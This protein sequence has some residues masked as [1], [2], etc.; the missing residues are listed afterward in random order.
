VQRLSFKESLPKG[1]RPDGRIPVN[2]QY[3]VDAKNLSCTPFGAKVMRSFQQPITD[4]ALT[5]ASITKS[6]PF[7]QLFVGKSATLLA[8]ATSIFDVTKSDSGNWTVGART[9]YSWEDFLVDGS[10][11]AGTIPAGKDW[12]FLD[13]WDRWMLFNGECV[14]FTLLGITFVQ[15]SVTIQTGAAYND[16]QIF[17]GGFDA[18]DLFSLADWPTY[19]ATYQTNLPAELQDGDY[20]TGM[21]ANHVWWSSAAGEDM[22][23]FFSLD[24]MKYG[25]PA[26]GQGVGT[27]FTEQNPYW[28]Q[29]A[30]RGESASAPMPWT[31]TVKRIMQ[32]G[33]TMI[34]YGTNGVRLIRPDGG[35]G[36]FDLP[37][38]A[39]NVGLCEGTTVR[40]AVGGNEQT[41][42]FVD[43]RRDLWAVENQGGVPQATNLG[44]RNIFGS[45]TNVMVHH[46]PGENEFYFTGDS[47]FAYRLPVGGG[48]SKSPFLPTTV[49][50]GRANNASGP[51]GIRTLVSDN[52]TAYLQTN[53]FDNQGRNVVAN[54]V[55]IIVQVDAEDTTTGLQAALVYKRFPNDP[56]VGTTGYVTVD[57]RGVAKIPPTS[58]YMAYIQIT[59]PDRTTININDIIL[60]FDDGERRSISTCLP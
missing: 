12:H 20:G 43:E 10:L 34:A 29:F 21:G 13:L 5:A 30:S 25:A 42:M 17:Y 40:L 28:M 18:S 44:Y 26:L 50:Y 31:G 23:K 59:H 6:Y 4:A 38:F 48:L 32:C 16:G 56:S 22:F 54:A 39:Q 9:V 47:D 2:A 46:D 11:N 1:I 58:Y 14:V 33:N 45:A 53:W 27:V 51:V 15:S 3:L 55:R 24:L 60:E 49:G 35:Y 19:L 8:T 36:N 7:P 57:K 37:G 52:T 41:Q